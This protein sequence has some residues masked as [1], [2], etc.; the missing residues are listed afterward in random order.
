MTRVLIFARRNIVETMRSPL[1]Y[2]FGLALPVGIFAIMQA[3]VK[4]IGDAAA[5]VPM[6]GVDMFTGGVCIFASSFLSLFCAMLIS[7]DR[8]KSFLARLAVSPTTSVDFIVGYA[9]AVAPLAVAQ[10]GVTFIVALCFGLKPSVNVLPAILFSLLVAVLFIAIG[11]IFGSVFSEK[12]APPLCSAVVQIAA[13]LSGMWFDLDAIGG[14][15]DLFCHILPFSHAYDLIRFSLAGDYAR[16][17]APAL[18]VVAY[19]VVFAVA[20]WFAFSRSLKRA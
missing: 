11:V 2:I 5:S 3:V 6:F 7:S 20:A 10:T 13:L 15:F 1:S 18:V 12:N 4:G 9:L 19:A 17:W 16:V 8:Q 14:G